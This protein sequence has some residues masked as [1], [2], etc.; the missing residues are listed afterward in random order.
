[1][2]FSRVRIIL[3]ANLVVRDQLVYLS[4]WSLGLTDECLS[5]CRYIGHKGSQSLHMTNLLPFSQQAHVGHIPLSIDCI[6]L[7][8]RCHTIGLDPWCVFLLATVVSAPLAIVRAVTISDC[9]HPW[10]EHPQC[11]ALLLQSFTTEFQ[12][13]ILLVLQLQCILVLQLS[14]SALQVGQCGIQVSIIPL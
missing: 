9:S 14:N 6:Y 10:V 1:M 5:S 3:I 11:S 12:Q 4:F 2:L 8:R 13:A 7:H